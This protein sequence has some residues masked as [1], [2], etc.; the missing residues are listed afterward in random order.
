MIIAK[1]KCQMCGT[2]FEAKV[3]DRDDPLEHN[4]RGKPVRCPSCGSTRIETIQRV[5]QA[6]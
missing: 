5:R 1:L 4:A 2:R 3:L 6:G